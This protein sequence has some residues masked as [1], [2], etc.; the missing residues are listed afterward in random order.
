MAEPV[1]PNMERALAARQFPTITVWNRLEGRPRTENF[2]RALK[3]E[4]RDPLWMLTRQWQLGEFTAND[5]G[6]PVLAKLHVAS[7]RF[8]GY[9]PAGHPSRPF[10][11]EVPLEAQVERR[12]LP[13]QRGDQ[14]IALDLRLLMGR[15]WL[16]LLRPIGDFRDEFV[17]NYGIDLPDP[18]Q[19][20]AAEVCA[21]VDVW[22]RVA[23][24]AERS[25]DGYKLY[26]YLSDDSAHHAHDD[27]TIPADRHDEVDDLADRF[28]RWFTT[29]FLQPE[30]PEDHAWRPDY[31]EYQFGVS[32][33]DGDEPSVLVADE[34]HHGRLDW[35]NLDVDP[36]QASPGLEGLPQPAGDLATPTQTLLPAPLSFEGMPHNRWWTFEDARTNFGDVRPGTTDL[37]KLLL[38]EFGLVYA[39][40]WFLFPLTLPT[41]TTTRIRGLAVTNVFGERIW[42]EAAGRGQDEDWQRWSMYTLAV[43]GDE[44][45]TADTRFLLLPTVPKIQ[46]GQPL[47]DVLLIRD[48]MANMVWGIEDRVALPD[49]RSKPGLEAATDRRLF[50]ERLVSQ[51]PGPAPPDPAAPVRYQVMSSGVPE[52][53]IPF[54]PVHLPGDNREIQLQ[55]AALPRLID[56]DPAPPIKIRPLT[57]LL[58]EGLDTDP[59]AAYFLHEDEVPGSGARVRQSYQRTRWHQGRVVVWL[60]AQKETGRGPGSSNL[61]FDQLVPVGQAQT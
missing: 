1:I 40:D 52:N 45:V 37:A 53:W 8:D 3:A 39:N 41:G 5:A 51:H 47:E 32:V 12:P 36:G 17:S 58:R 56:R 38:I 15:Q 21:H 18:S 54:I 10:D 2:D 60:G 24:V 27:T 48:E 6:S 14:E 29:L 49:G 61:R 22:Q 25:M 20:P 34:Y 50:H 44:D 9:R 55:R 59:L 46:E 42:I 43:R 28:L 16:K 30:E 4:I 23:A 7:A 11:D 57:T 33:P 35:Y 13:F 19:E 26:R 31:L